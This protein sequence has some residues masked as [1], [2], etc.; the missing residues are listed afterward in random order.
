MGLSLRGVVKI[1]QVDFGCKLNLETF[2]GNEILVQ[3]NIFM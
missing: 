2:L 3:S 1:F